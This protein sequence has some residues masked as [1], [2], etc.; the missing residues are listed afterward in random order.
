MKDSEYYAARLRAEREAAAAA[1]CDQAR[2]SHLTLAEHYMQVLEGGAKVTSLK[3][4]V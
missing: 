1:T 2:A 3:Q 4:S